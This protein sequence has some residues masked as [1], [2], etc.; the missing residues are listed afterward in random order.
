MGFFQPSPPPF[1]LE[2]WKAAGSEG[3]VVLRSTVMDPFL[4]ADSGT[5][6]IGGFLAALG[7]AA[8]DALSPAASPS[9]PRRSRAP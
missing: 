4:A 2:E 3:L 6:H 5:D 1:D 8:S 7:R 9:P